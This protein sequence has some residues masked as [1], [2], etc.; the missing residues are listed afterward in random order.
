M[1]DEDEFIDYFTRS[2]FKPPR[3]SVFDDYEHNDGPPLMRMLI[4]QQAF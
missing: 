4:M 3:G 2:A 1:Q